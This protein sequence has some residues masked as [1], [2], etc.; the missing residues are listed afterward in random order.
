[1]DKDFSKVY[2]DNAAST[3]I[4]DQVLDAMLPYLKDQYG[5]PSSHHFAGRETRIAIEE[6]R[7]KIASLLSVKPRNI[8]FTSGGTESNN[9]AIR[10]ALKD[11]GC[12]HIVTSKI[13]HHSVLNTVEHYANECNVTVSYVKLFED[14]S[15]DQ[16]D[17]RRLLEMKSAQGKKCFVT[18]MHANNETGQI[19]EVRWISSLCKKYGAVFHSD[20]VQTIRFSL[21]KFNSKQEIHYVAE[22]MGELLQSSSVATTA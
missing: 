3:K 7:K 13:E 19:T 8:I 16:N 9:L 5:N 11:F 17:F 22:V 2:L 15:I 6:A 1:M 21:S 18:L 20:F 4:D 14:G 12:N 10:A